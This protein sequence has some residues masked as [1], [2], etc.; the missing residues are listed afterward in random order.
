MRWPGKAHTPLR[1]VK[2]TIQWYLLKTAP[3]GRT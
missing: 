2:P 1:K 3:D